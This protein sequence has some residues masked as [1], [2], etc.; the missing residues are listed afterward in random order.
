M[1]SYTIGPKIGLDG[2]KEFR[3]SLNSI[4]ETLRTLDSELKKTASEFEDNADSQ[5]ALKAK[6]E[7]LN[8]SI[9]QQEKKLTE[10]KK[11]L[12]FAKK[13]YGDSATQTQ[14]WQRVLNNTET[15][16]NKLKSQVKKMNRLLRIW[17]MLLMMLTLHLMIWAILQLLLLIRQAS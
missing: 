17:I 7:V 1:S 2:E 14:K 4:N 6:N 10:V 8:K 16:L 3:S 15:D 13:E 12:E 9:E 5:E 11:A